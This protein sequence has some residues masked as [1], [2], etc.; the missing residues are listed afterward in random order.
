MSSGFFF[1]NSFLMLERSMNFQWTK[2]RATLD[3]IINAETPGYK[4]KYVT[5]EDAF[6]TQL[7][8]AA[9]EGQPASVM[10]GVVSTAMPVVH[11]AYPETARLDDNGV[12]V[13]EQLVEATRNTY[14]I[15]YVMDS[16]NSDLTRLRAAIRGQ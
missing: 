3:N 2:Q 16:M 15:Q 8:A 10:R 7:L 6:R 9:A 11:T 1:S 14:Q 12:N 5:F 13:G 4:A